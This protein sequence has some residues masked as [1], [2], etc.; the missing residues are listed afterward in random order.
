[1]SELTQLCAAHAI[2]KIREAPIAAEPFPH[3]IVPELLPPDFFRELGRSFPERSLFRNAAYPGSGHNRR[4]TPYHENGL[5]FRDFDANEYLR[6]LRDFF[7]SEDFSRLL[8]SKFS[9][10][11]PDGSTPIPREKFKFFASGASDY[12]CVFDIQIDR[13]GYEVAPHADVAEKIITF[14]LFLVE[15]EAL[16]PYGTLLCKPKAGTPTA[17]RPLLTRTTGKVLDRVLRR[18]KLNQ[19]KLYHVIERS[20]LGLTLGIG[21]NRSWLP[22]ELFDIARVAPALPNYFLAF[23]PNERSYHAVRLDDSRHERRVLRGFIRSGN[24]AANW[25]DVVAP[26]AGSKPG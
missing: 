4:A 8:L 12:T 1:V 10:S 17:A 11:L 2:R 5:V 25:V 22:W 18:T 3:I 14:Q 6:A 19:S 16:R 21:D 24:N 15:N 23:A 13:P 7:A 26:K 20:P 9:A